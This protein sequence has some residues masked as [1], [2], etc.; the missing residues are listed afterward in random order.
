MVEKKTASKA[1]RA[2][3]PGTL[4]R[5][6]FSKSISNLSAFRS[7]WAAASQI[8]SACRIPLRVTGGRSP[9]GLRAGL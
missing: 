8:G 6:S 7:L 2:A 3:M 4:S 1:A 5:P 9:D